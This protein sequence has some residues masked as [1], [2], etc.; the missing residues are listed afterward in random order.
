[1][2]R[3]LPPILSRNGNVRQI[4][5]PV[6]AHS[7]HA[8]DPG[9]MN[10][11]PPRLVGASPYTPEREDVLSTIVPDKSIRGQ[12][13]SARIVLDGTYTLQSPGYVQVAHLSLDKPRPVNLY[14]GPTPNSQQDI[15]T[16]LFCR[17]T[18]AR[19]K[20]FERLFFDIP[21]YAPIVGGV[22]KPAVAGGPLISI[23]VT[24]QD[25]DLSAKIV[26]TSAALTAAQWNLIDINNPPDVGP[27]GSAFPFNISAFIGDAEAIPRTRYPARHVSVVLGNVTNTT[28]RIGA[29]F[30]CDRALL[31]VD[32]TAGV[33][34]QQD[35]N[36]TGNSIGNLPLNTEVPMLGNL[37]T[38]TIT[39]GSG[40]GGA[41][42][43]IELVQYL[44]L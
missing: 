22:V 33:K 34:W 5:L 6:R 36:T 44:S 37:A 10:M 35:S 24:A 11:P 13:G 4:Q 15:G 20:T 12:G 3:D 14:V 43:L 7:L 8:R 40:A 26:A 18:I 19:G 16:Q 31:L 21:I 32:P 17:L 39:N 25:I 29:A 38:Y 9:N 27:G 2:A 28:L 1:M 41:P 30:G 23:P 42:A